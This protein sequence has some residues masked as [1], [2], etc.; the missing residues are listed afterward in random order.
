MTKKCINPGVQQ[1]NNPTQQ[2]SNSAT[3]QP[4]TAKR[5][6]NIEFSLIRQ[7]NALATPLCVNLGIGEPNVEPDETLREFAVRAASTGSWHYTANAGTMALRKL[8]AAG[9]AG[10]QPAPLPVLP[11]TD[12][13]G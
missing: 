11:R 13:R 12:E 6:E 3:Q 7:I 5:L 10:A 9:S 4:R 1:P 8:I 2:P